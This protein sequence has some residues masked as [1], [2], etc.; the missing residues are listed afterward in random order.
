MNRKPSNWDSNDKHF[1]DTDFST[2]S[3]NDLRQETT[4]QL[5]RNQNL[6]SLTNQFNDLDFDQ[7]TLDVP[8]REMNHSENDLIE[9]TRKLEKIELMISNNHQVV[10]LKLDRLLNE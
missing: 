9:L 5:D 10:E 7:N 6:L 3:N 4:N 1:F 8:M 2:F